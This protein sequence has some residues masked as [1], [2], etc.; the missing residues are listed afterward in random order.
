MADTTGMVEHHASVTVNAPV[1]QMYSMFTHFN[2]WR[3]D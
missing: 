2:D 3:L 1:H